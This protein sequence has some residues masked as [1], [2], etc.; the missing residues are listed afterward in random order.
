M[1]AFELV[2][3]D[4]TDAPMFRDI[5]KKYRGGQ[6]RLMRALDLGLTEEIPKLVA[7]GADISMKDEM[8]R[9]ALDWAA[10]ADSKTSASRVS[11]SEKASVAPNSAKA[12]SRAVT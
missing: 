10:W 2:N 11:S 1:R 8:Q 7:K 6:M 5:N 9:T 3:P 4:D 12:R